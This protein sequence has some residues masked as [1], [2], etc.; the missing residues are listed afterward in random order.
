MARMTHWLII[1]DHDCAHPETITRVEALEDSPVKD[2][3]LVAAE[4]VG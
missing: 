3:N 1:T 4:Y 2:D